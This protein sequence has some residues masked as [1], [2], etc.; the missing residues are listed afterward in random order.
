MV[1]ED[2]GISPLP[3]AGEKTAGIGEVDLEAGAKIICP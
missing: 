1:S 2:P 3:L